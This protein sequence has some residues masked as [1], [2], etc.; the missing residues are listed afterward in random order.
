MFQPMAA[1]PA[2]D[3]V[4]TACGNQRSNLKL[5]DKTSIAMQNIAN[6]PNIIIGSDS[7]YPYK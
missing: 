1:L 5:T 3:F 7:E 6:I 4:D 2:Q